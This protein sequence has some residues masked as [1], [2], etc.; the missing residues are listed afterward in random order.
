MENA[1]LGAPRLRAA[2]DL[3]SSGGPLGLRSLP[4]LRGALRGTLLLAWAALRTVHGEM[5]TRDQP[6]FARILPGASGNRFVNSS[7]PSM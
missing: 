3:R 7:G 1:L 6:W 5:W 2:D 4:A